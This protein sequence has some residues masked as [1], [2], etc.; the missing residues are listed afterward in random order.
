MTTIAEQIVRIQTAIANAYTACQ[1][2]GAT[3]PL[4]Q[5]SDH[6]EA[7][8]ASIS[9]G[10][11]ASQG[12]FVISGTNNKLSYSFDLLEWNDI[13]L[14]NEINWVTFCDNKFV[15]VTYGSNAYL[16][17]SN[18]EDWTTGT[19]PIQKNWET[20]AS[21]NGIIIAVGDAENGLN[22]C[23]YSTDGIN[24]SSSTI[25]GGRDCH[26]IRYLSG[27]FYA[28]TNTSQYDTYAVSTDGI[29][30]TQYTLPS[31]S[32]SFTIWEDIS[33]GNNKFIAISNSNVYA[34]SSD[35]INWTMATLPENA[36]WLQVCYGDNKFVI[37]GKDTSSSLYSSDGIN[38]TS[39]NLPKSGNWSVLL[40]N[41]KE[42][43]TL[44]YYKEYYAYSL[45]GIDWI[46][47]TLSSGFQSF[48]IAY[49]EVQ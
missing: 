48:D 7:C 12:K 28:F 33:Y 18:G 26:R 30:W 3:M 32:G 46:Q 34:Y 16:Y 31:L 23:V 24:W 41:G 5:D 49:G 42:F 38:W 9:G 11:P 29:N 15:G 1:D 21:G 37:T 35:G 19:L 4:V 43:V 20:I 17:S 40:F 6:L 8:I 14:P 44:D 13:T 27:K 22:Q 2:M 45:N 47:G 39:S 10:Q 25:P 36:F